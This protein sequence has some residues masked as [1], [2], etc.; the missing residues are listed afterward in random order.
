MINLLKRVY[1]SVWIFCLIVIFSACKKDSTDG[2]LTVEAY[3]G[4]EVYVAGDVKSSRAVLWKNG[5]PIYL[6]DEN[7]SGVAHDVIGFGDD[8]YVAG[9]SSKFALPATQNIRNATYW[10]NDKKTVIETNIDAD[11]AKMHRAPNG[12]LY[13]FGNNYELPGSWGTVWKNNMPY[14]LEK[15]GERFG[16][17]SMTVHGTDFYVVGSSLVNNVWIGTMWKN[18]KVV[19]RLGYRSNIEYVASDGTN[20]YYHVRANEDPATGKDSYK[21]Y[22][23][24]S[25]QYTL[26]LTEADFDAGF[27]SFGFQ[28]GADSYVAMGVVIDSDTERKEVRVWKNGIQLPASLQDIYSLTAFFVKGSD[29][30]MAVFRDEGGIHLKPELY[31]NNQLLPTNLDGNSSAGFHAIYVK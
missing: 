8:I 21:V 7:R 2:D 16:V 18:G 14:P 6:D 25:L 10:H 27:D 13:F 26:A 15:I 22:K 23:N 28:A 29:L 3:E 24:N 1:G 9:V 12:D 19:T 4:I 30:Y 31:K 17:F 20:L 11:I 5:E